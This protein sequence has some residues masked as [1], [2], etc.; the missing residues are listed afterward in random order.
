[1]M[2]QF[3]VT[4]GRTTRLLSFQPGEESFNLLKDKLAAYFPEA[5]H[6]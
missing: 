2:V 4:D 1:M 5:Y 6:V 3:K